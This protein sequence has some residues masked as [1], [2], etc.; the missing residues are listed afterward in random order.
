MDEAT[1]ARALEAALFAWRGDADESSARRRLAGLRRALGDARG[2]LSV[3]QETEAWFPDQAASLRPEITA[4][5]RAVLEQELP[6]AAVARFESHPDALPEDARSDAALML[7]DRL[8]ALDLPERAAALLRQAMDR[9]SGA[10]R[11]G[12]GARLAAL[13][14]A[15]GDAAGASAALESSQASSLPAALARDRALLAARADARQGH[16]ATALQMLDSLGAEGLAL[17]AELLA[18]AQD[19]S[20]AAAASGLHLRASLPDPPA[21][22]EEGHRRLLLRQ[23]AMLALAGDDSGLAQLRAAQSGR[24]QNGALAEAFA[25]LTADP[26]RG[27][28]DLPRLQRELQLFRNVPARLEALRSGGPVAR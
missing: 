22:L 6:L 20:G 25:L 10:A 17:R 8:A 27:L 23:A 14:L 19:W 5:F 28:A 26:L 13:R 9:A 4:A 15:E 1:A 11:A 12:L 21:P 7:A 16:L 3:L 18:D 24:M 2:A